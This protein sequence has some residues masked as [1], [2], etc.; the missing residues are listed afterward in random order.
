MYYSRSLSERIKIR[1]EIWY[2]NIIDFL[3][4][5][6]TRKPLLVLV[7]LAVLVTYRNSRHSITSLK[8]SYLSPFRSKFGLTSGSSSY[9][10]FSPY[11]STATGAAGASTY[12]R[13]SAYGGQQAQAGAYG[14]QAAYGSTAAGA[15]GAYGSTNP[16]GAAGASRVAPQQAAYGRTASGVG[17]AGGYSQ[18]QQSAYGAA[19]GAATSSAY[20]ASNNLRG[21]Q[22]QSAYG[23]ATA[24]TSGVGASVSASSAGFSTSRLVDQY[25]SSGSLQIAQGGLFQD[26]GMTTQFMGQIDTVDA[27]ES[28]A[29]VQQVLSTPGTCMFV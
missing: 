23:A 8:Q 7:G 25:G 16:Y 17:T 3:G 1:L 24:T 29:T 5:N 6:N 2:E 10:Q 19:G 22:T 12:G 20:G 9:S 18:Q 14:Q 13:N 4:S 15:A 27:V 26:Y 11:G 28:P 21:T